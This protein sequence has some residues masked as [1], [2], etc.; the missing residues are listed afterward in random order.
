MATQKLTIDQLAAL[1]HSAGFTA[2]QSRTMAAIAM[3]ESSGNVTVVN[4]IGATGLWQ[5]NQP[6]W[7]KQYPS[8]TKAYLQ[9][10]L[11]N[12]K[13][14]KTVFDAKGLTAWT[15]YTSGAYKK[16]LPSQSL[17]DQAISQAGNLLKDITGGVSN[18]GNDAKGLLGQVLQLPSQVTD[19]LSAMEAPLKAVM[20]FL[21]P[22]SWVRILAG[23][24]G[25]LLLGAGI[26]TLAKAA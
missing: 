1:A 21:N 3:A 26:F 24:F 10:P 25:F 19:A 8:W 16:Y 2:D 20:W 23:V 14:A 15:V 5:I 9:D 22:A 17:V 18:L 11:N 12:A 7:D 13:A 6:V 4:S